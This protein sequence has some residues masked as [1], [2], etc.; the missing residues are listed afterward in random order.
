MSRQPSSQKALQNAAVRI[1]P[2]FRKAF[3][4]AVQRMRSRIAI[5]ALADALSAKNTAKAL[6]AI[7]ED[8]IEEALKPLTGII[9]DSFEKG[10]KMGAR[11]V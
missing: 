6:R 1:A 9:R 2:R 8:E 3:L 4:K 7:G 10:G 5:L 11:L